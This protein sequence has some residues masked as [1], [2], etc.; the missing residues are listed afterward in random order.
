MGRVYSWPYPIQLIYPCI[1]D[2]FTQLVPIPNC[3]PVCLS[4]DIQ[5]T[6]IP[7][8]PKKWLNYP[9]NLKNFQKYP[10]NFKITKILL[11]SK[12]WLKYPWNLKFD[13]N[14]PKT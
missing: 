14:T 9:Q 3:Y 5:T 4:M 2:Y 1:L 7:P 6:E 10:R 11:E 13:W 8:K 12:K